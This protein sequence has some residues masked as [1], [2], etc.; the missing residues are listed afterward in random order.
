MSI[1]KLRQEYRRRLG[2]EAI[3]HR[4]PKTESILNFADGG[5]ATRIETALRIVTAMGY[6]IGQNNLPRREAGS[7]FETI[8]CAF[9]PE[10]F[11]YLSHVRPSPWHYGLRKDIANSSSMLT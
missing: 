5:N 6:G 11:V 10:A 3:R 7:L 2:R 4:P 9:L 8:T 1:G